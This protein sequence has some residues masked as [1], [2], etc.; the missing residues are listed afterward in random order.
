[1]ADLEDKNKLTYPVQIGDQKITVIDTEPFIQRGLQELDNYYTTKLA[2]IKEDYDDLLDDYNINRRVYSSKFNFQPIIGET[3]HLYLNSFDEEFLSLI[4][5][6]EWSMKYLGSFIL[7][8]E[9]RWKQIK[10][11]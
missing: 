10:L 11:K 3:Y 1:M 6:N 4:A 7:N 5:P 8:S 2:E 9:N